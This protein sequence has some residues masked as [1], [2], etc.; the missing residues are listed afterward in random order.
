MP[1][2]KKYSE[3]LTESEK[4]QLLTEERKELSTEI[5]KCKNCKKARPMIFAGL[6][7]C[8]RHRA[9]RKKDDFCSFGK[10]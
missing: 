8:R 9:C 7:Y 3:S 1:N 10:E 6:Y 4:A 2:V 5:V